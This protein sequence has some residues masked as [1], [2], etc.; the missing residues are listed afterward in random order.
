VLTLPLLLAPACGEDKGTE[1]TTASGVEPGVSAPL[2][3]EP[4]DTTA[5]PTNSPPGV[6]SPP[7]GTSS[8]APPATTTVVTPSNAPTQPAPDPT[9]SQAPTPGP[10]QTTQPST[11]TSTTGGTGGAEPEPTATGTVGPAG[12]AGGMGTETPAGGAGGTGDP[13]PPEPSASDV[14]PASPGTAPSSD[15]QAVLVESVELPDFDFHLFEG[16]V[17]IGDALYFSDIKPSPWNSTLRRYE[18]AADMATDFLVGAA[19]NGLAVDA[20]GVLYSA[21]AGKKEISRYDLA[22]KTQETAV[23]GPFN[24]PNDIA[25]AKDGTIYF[26]DPQQG[27]I[28]AGNLPQLVH[29][30]KSGQDAIF[31]EEITAPNGVTLSPAEDI[32]Y[33]AGGGYTGFIKKVTLVDGLAGTIEDL[34]T[35]LQVPDGMTKDCAGN[36]YVA[37]HELQQVRVYSP[38]GELLSTISI[39]SAANG[40]GAKPTNVAFGGADGK[41]LFITATYSLWEIPL[42]I[43]GYPY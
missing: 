41:T 33:V 31:S 20:S 16:P 36:V 9:P 21:T 29:V 6:T 3:S 35:E 14:C 15:L 12:G 4:G 5:E 24:S 1:G 43:V 34:A 7:P 27:E 10:T 32:L 23:P 18:P 25:I 19:S 8:S 28:A 2:S 40:Q 13:Q 38:T 39:G 22:G 42:D 17:W 11:P 30:V 26:S 37:V